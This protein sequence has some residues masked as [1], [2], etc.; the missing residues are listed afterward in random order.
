[1]RSAKP[2]AE[3]NAVTI[4]MADDDEDDRVL[5]ADALDHS[6]SSTTCASSSTAKSCMHYLRREGAYGAGGI[7]APRPGLIL[8]DLNMPKK[9]GREALAEIKG[10]PDLRQ[11]PVVVLT[12]SRGEED[13]V[14]TYDLG[15]NSFVSKPVTFDGAG[16]RDAD[17][18]GLLV[19]ARRAPGAALTTMADTLRILLVEDD[20]DDYLLTRSMLG[21]Q[22]QAQFT[23][24]WERSFVPALTAI[25]EA[26]HDAL[27]DRLPARRS[28]RPRPRPRGMGERSAAPVIMLTGQGEYAVDLAGLRAG[29]HRLPGEGNDRR[30]QPGAHDPLRPPPAPDAGR[31]TAERGTLR[32]RG[33]RDQRRDLGLGPAGGDH[34]LLRALE[35]AAGL[36][37]EFAS[38]RPAAWFDLVHPDDVERLRREIDHHLT[39]SSPHFEN[40]HRI[41]H[42][43]GDWRWVLTRGLTTRNGL[44]TPIRITGSLSDVTERRNAQQRLIHD[45]LHDS[46]T[47]LPNRTLFM[48]RLVQCLSHLERDPTYACA[49]LY[50]D[51]DRFKMVNDSVS[52][53]AGDRMLTE[54][55]RRITRTLRPGDTLA[56]LGGDEFAVLLDGIDAPAQA[57]G[58]PAGPARSSPSRSD[59]TAQPVDRRQ[60]RNRPH[61]R[62]RRR[63]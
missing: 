10:D 47:G 45:A 8:L 20:E 39:G 1:M 28:H 30:A 12:T 63:L 32:R 5:T 43:D 15:V 21:T 49:V 13:I 58:S 24:D 9:D 26:R 62:R 11:I 56:R 51:L 6:R 18:R 34:A 50:I 14:R 52:H 23:L 17:A 40:E 48:D 16:G 57:L 60:H 33:T 27:P 41:R 3:H 22:G 4:L 7:P 53:A 35:D 44:G 54:L 59:S 61:V 36:R 29:R 38:G 31:P 55:A 37:D 46:L 2:A 25:R 19:R 42:A